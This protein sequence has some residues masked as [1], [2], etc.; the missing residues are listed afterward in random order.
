MTCS[1]T[2]Q[3]HNAHPGKPLILGV[4]STNIPP[5]IVVT[6]QEAVLSVPGAVDFYVIGDEDHAILTFTL[7]VVSSVYKCGCVAVLVFRADGFTGD[8]SVD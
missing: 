8:S 7:G 3:L 2:I 5:R 6:P 4:R 1:F